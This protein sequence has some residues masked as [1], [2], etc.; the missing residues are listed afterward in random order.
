M[1]CTNCGF[2]AGNDQK[3]PVCGQQLSPNRSQPPQQAAN[4][5]YQNNQ[6][7]PPYTYAQPVSRPPYP[8]QQPV[9]AAQPQNTPPKKSVNPWLIV[10]LCVV[11]IVITAGIVIAIMSSFIQNPVKNLY[12][13]SQI[14]EPEPYT[15]IS[16][17]GK[18][19]ISGSKV[20][21][22]G[23]SKDWQKYG[24]VT[25]SNFKKTAEQPPAETGYTK[26]SFEVELKNNTST[27]IETC[28]FNC[29]FI[30]TDGERLTTKFESD[31]IEKP[32]AQILSAE[33]SDCFVLKPGQAVSETVTV[34]VRNGIDKMYIEVEGNYYY[35]EL[36]NPLFEVD[37]TK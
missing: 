6:A 29:D 13:G 33:G 15:D 11:G 12:N 4:Y 20:H 35:P 31:D 17:F 19:D 1:K 34:G 3:C 26:Y 5:P 16:E 7:Q 25:V 24:A 8:Q 2:D 28:F 23:E 21:K 18:V 30:S 32:Y 9:T 36:E 22:L 10:L 27:D 37:L 14:F